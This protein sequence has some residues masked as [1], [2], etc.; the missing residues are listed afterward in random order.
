LSF[1]HILLGDQP[2]LAAE[3]QIYQRLLAMDDHEARAVADLYLSENSLLQLYDS[4]MIPALTMAEQDRHKGALDQA[5]EEFVFLSFKEMLAEFSEKTLEGE[6][7]GVATEVEAAPMDREPG[8]ASIGRVLCLPSNDEADEISAS[9]LA[10]LLEQ[11]GRR[12]VLSFPLDPSLQYLMVVEPSEKDVFCI[13]ALPPFAFARARILSRQLQMR[14]PRTETVVGIWGFT[15]DTELALQRF[16][17]S[18]PQKL[19]T[20]LAEAV[21]FLVATDPIE[22]ELSQENTRLLSVPN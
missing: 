6:P 21:K 13:S 5:R 1:L 9:M 2:V 20:S 19:V 11:A 3:A 16:Q 7:K 18:R 10:Q 12:A 14:F 22:R 4:V 15:G 17:P 8:T